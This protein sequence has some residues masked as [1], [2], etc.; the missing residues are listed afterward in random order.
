MLYRVAGELGATK[1]ALGHHRDDI[2]ET[3]FLNL[4]HGG[5]LKAM[6]P[7][8]VSDDGKHV[9]IRPLAYVEERDLAAYAELRGFPIIP[10]DLCGSQEQLQRKQV[11]AM[12]REWETQASRPARDPSSARLPM[13]RRRTCWT[14][15]SSTSQTS[16]PTGRARTHYRS[17]SRRRAPARRALG[18][19]MT[20]KQLAATKKITSFHPPQ[21]TLMGPGPTEIHPR[22]LTTMSQPAIGYLDPVFVE[23]MEELKSLLRYVYQTDNPLTFPVSGPGSVGMEY[24]FVNLVAPG[25]K[26]IVCRNGVFGGRMLENVERCGGTAVVVDDDWGK[27][28]DPQKVEDALQREQPGREASLAFVHA[29]TSTGA[30]S[31]AKALAADRAQARRA[32][33]RRRGDL[34]RRHAG[35]GRRLE[36]ST[37]STRRARSAC[38][39]RRACRPCRSPSAWSSA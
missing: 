12:L 35:A 15:R 13:S 18:S 29:E 7:K 17:I 1:I 30:Q 34:A 3:F 5:K 23:M 39:A 27:P 19:A 22:V 25:D 32:G 10:C 26:V 4:F 16:R 37:R 6:P 11:K 9:V 28:V 14:A 8:L 31:D 20:L 33:D 21:R 36:A 2:L 38:R 24:C